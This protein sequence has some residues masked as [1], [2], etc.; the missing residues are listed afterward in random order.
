MNGTNHDPGHP[1][2][3]ATPAGSDVSSDP[4]RD[5]SEGSDW[6]DEGGATPQGPA[7]DAPAE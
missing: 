5:D 3:E 4:G 2:D 7:T 1:G 6:T